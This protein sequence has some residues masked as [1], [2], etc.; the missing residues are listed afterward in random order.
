L[1][2]ERANSSS[3]VK[4]LW[5]RGFFVLLLLSLWSDPADAAQPLKYYFYRDLPYGTDSQFNP[6]QSFTNY[7]LDSLQVAESFRGDD[8]ESQIDDTVHRLINPVDSIDN[9]GG[10][11]NFVNRQVFPVDFDK[12]DNSTEML[13]NYALHLFGGGMVY[14]KNAEWFHAHGYPYPRTWA[15]VLA[16]FAE[17]VQEVIEKESTADDD[18]VADFWIFR[19]VGILLFTWD[20]FARFCSETLQL[21]EWPYQPMFDL[22]VGEIRNVGQSYAVR[23]ALF[24]AGKH[25]PFVY[26]GIT[27]LFGLSYRL[28][29]SDS[30]SWGAG[31]AVVNAQRDDVQL[32]AAGGMFYDR[33]GSLLASLI[34]NG[35]DDLAVRCNVHPGVIGAGRWSPGVFFGVGDDGEISVGLTIRLTPVGI[36]GEF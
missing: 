2:R 1:L 7:S 33:N 3:G 17:F 27:T 20:R 10:F 8:Y 23:P 28:N 15:A 36:S 26:F 6:I 22:R 12:L 35:S 34:F 19:P 5:R 18:P 13:P 31:A 9:E 25:R 14:R 29:A 24:G 32:R 21:V 11:V 4:F 16:M 30:L